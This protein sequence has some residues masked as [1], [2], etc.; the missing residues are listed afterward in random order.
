MISVRTLE[1]LATAAYHYNKEGNL[2]F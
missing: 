1:Q 2:S